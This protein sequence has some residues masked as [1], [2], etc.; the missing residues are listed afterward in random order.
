M[1]RCRFLVGVLESP[2]WV[3]GIIAHTVQHY[4]WQKQM[5]GRTS[6]ISTPAQVAEQILLQQLFLLGRLAVRL[7]QVVQPDTCILV[8]RELCRSLGLP[9]TY[10]IRRLLHVASFAFNTEVEQLL[11]CSTKHHFLGCFHCW[12]VLLNISFLAASIV[13]VFY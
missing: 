13:G 3:G 7:P 5:I 6:G 8:L 4:L 1:T 11:G 9:N 2:A 10:G 12:G